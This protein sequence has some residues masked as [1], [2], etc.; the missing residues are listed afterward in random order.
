MDD[1]GDGAEGFDDSSVDVS[2]VDT[3]SIDV[4]SS[5]EDVGSIPELDSDAFE[6]GDIA[7]TEVPDIEEPV[8]VEALEPEIV[9]S[10][11]PDESES[12]A[13]EAIDEQD[14]PELEDDATG[15]VE[16]SDTPQEWTEGETV[17][18]D[19]DDTGQEINEALQTETDSSDADIPVLED[20][21][22]AF[23][24]EEA[25][26]SGINLD[27]ESVVAEEE[28]A[29]VDANEPQQLNE[30]EVEEINHDDLINETSEADTQEATA[31]EEDEVSS[32]DMPDH[33]DAPFDT[34]VFSDDE[35]PELEDD[36]PFV[37]EEI[38]PAGGG[39]P[40]TETSPEELSIGPV[41]SPDDAPEPM[42][43]NEEI[44]IDHNEV[45]ESTEDEIPELEDD[46]PFVQ[47]EIDTPGMDLDGAENPEEILKD[48]TELPD[49]SFDSSPDVTPQDIQEG[50]DAL[51]YEM[52]ED[53][54]SLD[55]KFVEQTDLPYVGEQFHDVLPA[56][57]QT[58]VGSL[59]ENATEAGD[60]EDAG[61][62]K[63]LE[64]I[65]GWISDINPNFDPFDLDSVYDNNCG[66]CAF[67]V[68]QQ[69]EGNTDAV[70]EPKVIGTIEEMNALTGKEQI[71]MG[72][73]EIK[74]YLIEQGP[75]SH[76]VVGI[77]RVD[78]YGHWFNAYY[79]GDRVVALDGQTGEIQ[80]WPPDYGQVKNWDFSIKKKE[81]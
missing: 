77:D 52:E 41:E 36:A 56:E 58:D 50:S 66:S 9:E 20:G 24:Q 44:K 45:S 28:M 39:L 15:P 80:D 42:E 67:A 10:D 35:I 21:D 61:E 27:T 53:A 54:T 51:Q 43:E 1:F 47:D 13:V 5:S 48:P 12:A 37:Q 69:L 73:E 26:E 78:S 70:A 4:D 30:G 34:S 14:I 55:N 32:I 62:P 22:E 72:P 7:E 76:G 63:S 68:E 8:E 60:V 25:D 65:G 18:I 2:D 64:D 33:S 23:I 19:H 16:V 71:S 74:D 59:D 75:G 46:A 29:D 17:T 40:E 11:I 81:L 38:D 6:L 31:L 79:D 49:D 57:A 3:G